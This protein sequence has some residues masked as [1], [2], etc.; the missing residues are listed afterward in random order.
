MK[1][2]CLSGQFLLFGL[3]SLGTCFPPCPLERLLLGAYGPYLV[4]QLLKSLLNGDGYL[5]LG[6]YTLARIGEQLVYNVIAIDM[7]KVL[8]ETM[9]N[10]VIQEQVCLSKHL[11]LYYVNVIYL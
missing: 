1:A 9:R 2:Q 7:S 6:Y 5:V 4:G 3:I 8:A 10:E 11:A